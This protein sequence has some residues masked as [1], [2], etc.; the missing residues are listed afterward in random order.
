MLSRIGNL[1]P[2]PRDSSE[3][4]NYFF[5]G[6]TPSTSTPACVSLSSLCNNR[7]DHQALDIIL[8]LDNP[9]YMWRQTPLDL[10][11]DSHTQHKQQH[12]MWLGFFLLY[13]R[14]NIKPYMS[15]G[16]GLS[17]KIL[18]KKKK[19]HELRS[20]E[21]NFRSIEP[22]RNWTVIFYNYSIPTLHINILWVSLKQD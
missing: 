21:S 12:K 17:W 11:R 19:M 9:K 14:K 8:I 4:M 18:Q 10:T 20:V 22:C 6:F 13:L 2:Q 16:L 5:L 7:T 15:N 1:L 3:S